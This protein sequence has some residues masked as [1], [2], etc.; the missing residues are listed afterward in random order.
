MPGVF[1]LS[2]AFLSGKSDS[3]WFYF[4]QINLFII[5]LLA[6][7]FGLEGLEPAGISDIALE[8]RKILGCSMFKSRHLYFYQ[9][10]MLV[11][12][13]LFRIS[14]YLIHPSRE[15]GYRRG[16]SHSDFVTS[17]WLSGYPLP[18]NNLRQA[19]SG[20]AGALRTLLI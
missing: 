19:F 13:D 12:P 4:Q 8:G 5:D 9:G 14:T 2:C 7:R 20:E 16:R 10:S 11:N 18:I 6:R 3:P 15:P 1:C 17:L